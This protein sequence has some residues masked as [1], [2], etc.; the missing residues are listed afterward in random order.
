MQSS[1]ILELNDRLVVLLKQWDNSLGVLPVW[2][3]PE[4]HRV[5]SPEPVRGEQR[6]SCILHHWK[7]G[8]EYTLNELSSSQYNHKSGHAQ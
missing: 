3:Q 1:C 7:G 8:T 6:C 4:L 2:S 5:I